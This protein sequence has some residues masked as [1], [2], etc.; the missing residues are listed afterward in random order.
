MPLSQNGPAL[1]AGST[2]Q[3][4]PQAEIHLYDLVQLCHCRLRCGPLGSWIRPDTRK[5]HLDQSPSHVSVFSL[6]VKA[7]RPALLVNF[8]PDRAQMGPV[9]GLDGELAPPPH[10]PPPLLSFNSPLAS[11]PSGPDQAFDVDANNDQ[12]DVDQQDGRARDDWRGNGG[13]SESESE[14]ELE[15]EDGLPSGPDN[16]SNVPDGPIEGHERDDGDDDDHWALMGENRVPVGRAGVEEEAARIVRE[17]REREGLGDE[18][19]LDDLYEVGNIELELDEDSE[20]E[21]PD[22]KSLVSHVMGQ[23]CEGLMSLL[24]PQSSCPSLPQLRAQTANW[25]QKIASS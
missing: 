11:F 9:D 6:P 4:P 3:R 8:G 7:W 19:G 20:D 21:L 15:E 14:A 24:G 5:R 13:E 17:M 18:D 1:P 25:A 16:P 23:L 12:M 2:R 22:G 10:L